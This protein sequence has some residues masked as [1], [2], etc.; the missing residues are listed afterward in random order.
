MVSPTHCT[1][2]LLKLTSHD[3][4][5]TFPPFYNN[6]FLLTMAM[7]RVTFTT[8]ERFRGLMLCTYLQLEY[9]LY[10]NILSRRSVGHLFAGIRH[11]LF[12]FRLYRRL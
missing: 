7:D 4:V 10:P 8:R 1:D 11:I 3:D 6:P 2:P 5:Q 9:T 12:S